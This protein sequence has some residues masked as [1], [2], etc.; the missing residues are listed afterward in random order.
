MSDVLVKRR[1]DVLAI[2]DRALQAVWPERKGD[3]FVRTTRWAVSELEAIA[4]EMLKQCLD[5]VERSRTYRHLGG[6]YADLEPTLGREMLLKAKEAYQSAE[7]LL[8]G[9]S[10]ELERAK[11][12]YN[13]AN[14]ERHIDLNDVDQLQDAKRRLLSARKYFAANAPQYLANVD[15]VLQ[16]VESLLELAPLAIAVNHNTDDMTA[17]QKQLSA[18]G[19]VDEIGEKAHQIMSRG[20]GVAGIVGQLRKVIEELP[21]DRRRTEQ[22]GEIQ[23][24]MQSLTEQVLGGY[25]MTP[26]EKQILDL[27]G[28]AL[29]QEAGARKTSD[30]RAETLRGLLEEFG[31]AMSGDESNVEALRAKVQ[32]MKEVAE[33]KLEL[34]HY[35]SHGIE[36]PPVGT[37]AADLVELNWQLRRYLLEELSRPEKGSEES[38]EAL[39][40]AVRADRVDRR[41]YEAGADDFQALTI[42]T[43]ELRPLAFAVRNFSARTYIMP[44]QPI[45]RSVSVTVDTNAV[46]YSGPPG[47]E[48]LVRAACRRSGLQVM[49]AP[50]GES[51]AAARWKQLQKAVTAVFDLR[52]TDGPELASVTYELGISLTIGR[53]VVVL[54]AKEEPIP[55]DVDIDPVILEGGPGDDVALASAIDGSVVSTYPGSSADPASKTLE[56]VL[57]IYPR[58]QQNTSVDQMLRMLT[59]LRKEPDPL[60]L[61][62]S[63]VKLFDYFHDGKTMLIRPHWPAAY[64]NGNNPRLFHVMPFRP[65]WADEVTAMAREM[66]EA[67]GVTYIRGDEVDEPDVISSIWEEIGRA[68]HVLV[69]LSG[70]NANVALELGIAHTLGKKVLM[71]AQEDSVDRLFL[72]VRRRRVYK[73]NMEQPKQT[74]GSVISRFVS[75]IKPSPPRTRQRGPVR[76][77]SP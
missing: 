71:V 32:R 38:R 74:L 22:F 10:D 33:S 23:K 58:T 31:R 35:L 4:A 7:A 26:D 18:G 69:D 29:K 73:Y 44:A 15:A 46:F 76:D 53:P 61:T 17:L 56:Y 50:E 13:F 11:L 65:E 57:S 3:D 5:P 72:S 47:G 8:E 19:N 28:Q 62:R 41:I 14:T 6:L 67:G 40:L 70:F 25:E 77:S 60:A 2:A 20:G 1:D 16:S 63:L 54:V 37:R 43:E 52:L 68:T 48:T 75:I 34:T 66:S 45:W 39:D 9:Q 12:N 64:P 30:S 49:S 21:P 24:Q 59:A 36:R 55:F 51:Y 42:E 27:V